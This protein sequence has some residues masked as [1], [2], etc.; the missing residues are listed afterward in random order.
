MEQIEQPKKSR[1][2]LALV[3]A[4]LCAVVLFPAAAPADTYRVKAT[5]DDTWNPSYRH[6]VKGSKIVWVNPAHHNTVHDMTAYGR[7]WSKRAVLEPGERT[8][9]VFKRVGTYKYRC[10]LHSARVDGRCEGMCGV[11]HVA[12]S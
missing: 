3:A 2:W 8:R 10:V 9:K 11:I 6:V 5:M 7:N 1:R 4:S 12:R